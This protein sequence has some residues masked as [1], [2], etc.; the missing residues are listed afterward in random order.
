MQKAVD[1]GRSKT[2]TQRSHFEKLNEIKDDVF[3][4]PTV[5]TVKKDRFLEKAL[6]ASPLDKAIDSDK[7]Q[8][9]SLQSLMDMLAEQLKK[10]RS[11]VFFGRLNVRVRTNSFATS[12]G[13]A[14]QFSKNQG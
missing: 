3:I 6:D 10:R 11:L 1:K 9:P 13:K 4:Q 12:D 5:I 14:L 8:M 2:I 7:Y